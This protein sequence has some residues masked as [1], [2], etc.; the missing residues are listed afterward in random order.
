MKI[1]SNF[2]APLQAFLFSLLLQIWDILY[3]ENT[4]LL[5]IQQQSSYFNNG[6]LNPVS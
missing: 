2:P 3:F 1:L 5:Y 6:Y 4:G